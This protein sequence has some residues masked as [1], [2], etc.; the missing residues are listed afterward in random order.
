MK[1]I[2]QRILRSFKEKEPSVTEGL[3]VDSSDRKYQVLPGF[4]LRKK[5]SDADREAAKR[6]GGG[7]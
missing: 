7:I 5:K 4:R 2:G 3:R 1:Y 6:S